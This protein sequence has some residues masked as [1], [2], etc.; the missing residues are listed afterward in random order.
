MSLLLIHPTLLLSLLP[1]PSLPSSFPPSFPS[2][3]ILLPL[4][5][6]FFPLLPLQVKYY[7]L[8]TTPKRIYQFIGVVTRGDTPQFI[9][10]FT[11]YETV[12]GRVS[13]AFSISTVC[14]CDFVSLCTDCLHSNHLIH[15]ICTY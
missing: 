11:H 1:P 4:S 10:L 7:I 8:A 2:L 14:V 6:P 13:I 9:E 15:S 3:F 5:L 12:K